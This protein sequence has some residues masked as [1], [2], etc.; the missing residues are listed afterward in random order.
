MFCEK[1]RTGTM[2]P[3]AN[4]AVHQMNT[5]FGTNRITPVK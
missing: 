3:Q 2:L 1:D 5:W 4:Q